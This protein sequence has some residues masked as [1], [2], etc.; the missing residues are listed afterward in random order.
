MKPA[1]YVSALVVVAI[2]VLL[3][4]CAGA[5]VT[6]FAQLNGTVRDESGGTIGKASVSLRETDTNRAYT[7]TTN[8]SGFYVVP[9]LPSGRYELKV[10]FAGFATYTQTGIAL[11]VG[12]TATIDVTLK[13][14]S[15]GEQVTVTGEAPTVEPTK[16]EIS[17]VIDDKQI[18]SLPISGR[19]F[20][21][22]ALLTPGVATGRTSLQ[23]TFTE[24]EVTR[25]SFGGMRDFSNIV[26][27]DGADTINT[28][29]SS[30]RATPSQEAVSEFRV[31]NNSFGADYGRA[32]GGIVNIVTKSGTNDWH[33][34]VY[35]YLQNDATNARSLLLPAPLANTLRQN[36]FGATLGGPIQ[37]DKTFFFMNYEGQ[38]RGEAPTF[39]S[40]LRTDL[41]IINAAKRALLP[42]TVGGAD[43]NL[44]LLKTA[45]TDNGFV[46]LDHQL[47]DKHRLTVRYNILD[48]RD[49]NVLVGNTLDGGGIGA[50]SSGHNLFLRDQAVVATL[51]SQ[52]K[53]NFIN[54][55]LF[56]FA[57][58]T[59]DFPG[60]TGQPNL[61]IPNTLLFGHNF[62]VFDYISESRLQFSDSVAWVKGS[63]VV[64]FGVDTNFNR[65]NVL[66]PGFTPMRIILPGINCLVAFANFVNPAAMVAPSAN[67]GDV[68]PLPPVL[69]G[70]PIIF[71]G[72]PLGFGPVAEGSLPPVIPTT[73]DT[74]FLPS[75]REDFTVHLDHSY[76]GFFAQ[77]QWKV[78][79][80]LTV[81]YG[82]RWDFEGGLTKQVKHDLNNFAPRLGLAYSPDK[83]TVI[84]AGGGIFYDRYNLGFF[85]VTSP[86]RPEAQACHIFNAANVMIVQPAPCDQ[87][88][89]PGPRQGAST[90]GYSLNQDPTVAGGPGF[91]ANA[92]LDA[93]NFLL[94]G[95]VPPNFF[96][97][98]NPMTTGRFLNTVAT[99]GV[100][101]N[102][103]T[104]YSEQ[105]SLE[106]NREIGW[107][108][109]VSA[110][111]LF[112][113]AHKLVRAENL[114]VSCPAGATQTRN[115]SNVL[116]N[117]TGGATLPDGKAAFQGPEYNGGLVY[118]TDNSGNSVYHGFT[119]Q[120]GEKAG[121]YFRLNANYTFSKTLDDGTYTTFVS[122]PQ[123]LFRRDLER[124]NSNQ[125][126]RH[127]FIANFVA[128]GPEKT[129]LRQFELSSIIT[130]QSARPFTIFAGFDTNNDT[131]PV[132]DR[133]G[134]AARNTYFGD[135]L[136]SA[137]LRLS[138]YFR[139][140]ERLKLQV[141]A[142]VFNL[143]NRANVDEVTSVYN[144]GDFCGP[145]P[146]SYKDAASR[147]I[148]AIQPC[149]VGTPGAPIANPL[150]GQPRTTFNPRQLQFAAKFTF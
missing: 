111:Y 132:T 69:N 105:A 126:V 110:G 68:C 66:W 74:P 103:R 19:L 72:A 130:A 116:V 113:A 114:N 62:G 73:F 97:P 15:K 108:M 102:S 38:R 84:R 16:T 90:A 142:E 85:F 100:D 94:T 80:K 7:G 70:T 76:Y 121:K 109:T 137:D 37:K 104:S 14:A 143:F 150:F 8:D 135:K 54:T 45:D 60:V 96:L 20:T 118:F 27:V 145:I 21:D 131:N 129:F 29:T 36:Q 89:L 39:P 52:L 83:H 101:P 123:N 139:L 17:Q 9:N 122:T 98:P 147:A 148:Q 134:L 41:A 81:N 106:I 42:N 57:R 43:E 99:D 50:P 55:F 4:P 107:G 78:T 112:V 92:A 56:Q 138:R 136:V 65:D 26:T 34:S 13:V 77:D 115:S 140:R 40:V 58:R 93:K 133:V 127:R 87:A 47:T 75:V 33:G 23:S 1:W 91:L 30:Q 141:I 67:P 35:D 82:L 64:N 125:D 24:F 53:P 146:M 11:T 25:V 79:P 124:A 28:V 86:Q 46:K 71:W 88:T 59:Y 44:S 49:L 32:L 18:G 3:A 51:S 144:H 31:V 48:A 149:P 12:Q 2:L 95:Q 61:D 120:V 63:H 128:T 119:F 6:S 5:Q 10:S 22:F 117:C